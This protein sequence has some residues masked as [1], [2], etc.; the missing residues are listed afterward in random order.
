MVI[1]N[2]QVMRYYTIHRSAEIQFILQTSETLN[3]TAEV[4][5]P[6]RNA[7]RINPLRRSQ[8]CDVA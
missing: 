5:T 8:L 1:C 2:D 3:H 7:L 4:G 6:Q